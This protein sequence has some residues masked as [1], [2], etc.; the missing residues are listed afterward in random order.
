[1]QVVNRAVELRVVGEVQARSLGCRDRPSRWDPLTHGPTHGAERDYCTATAVG[2]SGQHG[3]LQVSHS[4]GSAKDELRSIAR[5]AMVERGLLP[6]FSAAVIAETKAAPAGGAEAGPDVRDLRSLLWA[7]VDNDD[8][9]DLDQLSVAESLAGGAVKVLI[10]IADV[11]ALVKQGSATDDHARAN[12]TSVYTAAETFPMLPERF[13]TDLTSLNEGQSRLA[14]V[15]DLTVGADGAVTQS[16]CYR[17]VVC[18][19]VKLAYDG[20]GAWLDGSGPAPE[21]LAAVPGMMEQL[22]VQDGV[23][24]A[25]KRLRHRRG[26]LSLETIEARAVFEGDTLTDLLPDQKNRAKELIEDF[27]VAANS[28]VVSYL[29]QKGFPSLRRVLR[30]PERWQRIVALA[31][32]LGERLPKDADA[33]ALE[34]FLVKRRQA[35]PDTYQ[36]LSLSVVKLLGR[37]EYVP[38]AARQPGAGHFGL[39]VQ[40]YTH[41]TAP[42]RRYPD[43]V[44]QRL[45]KAAMAGAPV[46]YNGEELSG[47]AR[48]CTEQEDRAT[49][50]ER[51]VQKSAAALL[52]TA[53]VGEQF[54]AIVTGASAKGTWVRIA[55]PVVEGRVVRGFEG[56]DV[57]NRVGVRL[58]HTDVER[59]FIDFERV[60]EAVSRTRPG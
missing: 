47:L 56:L 11:D 33:R 29:G 46:P 45:L 52:L 23:A 13:S 8:S 57:G 18:N 17:A 7:S 12:T 25:L 37:G 14:V 55:R 27:M 4:P 9:R 32:G 44:M 49:K 40:D 6:D 15:V 50:V 5:R 28:A 36:D 42:N 19:R 58:V 30:S 51:Q 43:L 60:G 35:D 59:G 53:R 38:E 10:A 48:H 54:D 21:R 24:Q 31:A 41:A 2:G 1:M 3:V 39:A 16:S 26:A 22:R 34:E 20:V